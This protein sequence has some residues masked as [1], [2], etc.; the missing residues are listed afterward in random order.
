LQILDIIIATKLVCFVLE[1]SYEEKRKLKRVN[2]DA[3]G[4]GGYE[5]H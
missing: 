2:G 1:I 4:S 5:S 3:K